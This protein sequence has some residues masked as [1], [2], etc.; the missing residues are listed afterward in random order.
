MVVIVSAIVAA[1]VIFLL[2]GVRAAASYDF[3]VR[4]YGSKA[5]C[6]ALDNQ[7]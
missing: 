7:C 4:G 6:I 3:P 5:K 1:A 2:F